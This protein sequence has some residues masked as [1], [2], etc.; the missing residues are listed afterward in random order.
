MKTLIHIHTDFSYDS[1]IT[2]AQLARGC[3]EH[4]IGCVAVTDHDSIEG[5]RR[6]AAS[7]DIN[8]IIGEE[9][10]TRDGHLIGL[11]LE[12]WIPP[13]LSALDTAKA[14]R[15]Q[16]GLVLLPHPFVRA[17]SCGLGETAWQMPEWIDAVE[18]CNGQ[19]ISRRADRLA[20]A[21]AEAHDLPQYVGADSH[22]NTSLAPCYQM[23]AP[24]CDSRS[25]LV[26]LRKAEL[27]RG[28][29]PWTYFASTGYRLMLA[30]AGIRQPS[31]F[32][33]NVASA[34]PKPAPALVNA[35]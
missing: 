26:A 20:T 35:A 4:G 8:V 34:Q 17:F 27:V 14:I 6:L 25:F 21:F 33:A 24:A 3:E 11:F 31:L 30:L 16:G 10:T 5:A 12:E 28:L 32:G 23:M 22:M 13:G 9:V 18:V 2:V 19:N 7:T 1:N 15:E 29:H